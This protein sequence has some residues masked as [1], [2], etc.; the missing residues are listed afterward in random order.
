MKAVEVLIISEPNIKISQNKGLITDNRSDVAIQLLDK[1]IG[2]ES[3]EKGDGYVIIV[4]NRW[5]LYGCYVSPNIHISE[6]KKYIDSVMTNIRNSKKEAIFAGDLNAKSTAWG[7]PYTD[8]RGKYMEEWMDELNLVILNTGTTPTFERGNSRSFIDVTGTTTNIARKI[9]KWEVLTG[10]FLTFHNHIYFEMEQ[11][12]RQNYPQKSRVLFDVARFK[13]E[14]QETT[15]VNVPKNLHELCEILKDATRVSTLKVRGN[16]RTLPFWWNTEIEIQRKICM[17]LRRSI[18]RL[19]GKRG[20]TYV[21]EIINLQEQY[22]QARKD[23]KKFIAKSKRELWKELC[24]ELE[25]DIWG[26][27]YKVVMKN[28]GE[29]SLPFNLSEKRKEEIAEYLFPVKDDSWQKG[30]MTKQVTPFTLEEL[31]DATAKIKLG[32]APGPDQ[33]PPEA[34]KVAV[35]VIPDAILGIMNTLLRAQEF[36]DIWKIANVIFLWKGKPTELPSSFRTICMLSMLGKLFE[37][38]I[39]ERIE[40]EIE[41]NG[42]LSDRQYGFRKGRSTMQA[43]ERVT[44]VFKNSDK[45]WFVMV[46]VDVE[47]AFNCA[48]W[49][50]VIRELRSR[51][52]SSYLVNLVISY[53]EHRTIN[54]TKN[55][56]IEMTAGVP[57]GSVLGP[58]LWNIMY[59]RVLE[60]TLPDGATSVAYADDLVIMVEANT[61]I[62]VERTTNE[63]LYR[64]SSW[65]IRND[66]VLAPH[67]TEAIILKGGRSREQL[68]FHLRGTKIVP[69]QHLKYLGVYLN[70]KLSFAEH[71]KQVV[72]K[73]EVK[74]AQLTRILP[75]IGGPSSAKRAVMCG[76]IH[77]IVLY[78]AP[79]WH[80]VLSIKKYEIMMMGIQRRALLRIA[81]GYRTIS[82]SAVQVITGTPP[83]TLLAEERNRLYR[84]ENAHLKAV[85]EEERNI[86][87][88]KWQHEWEMNNETATWTRILIEDI[89][90]W[91][92]CKHRNLDYYLTQFLTGHGSFRQYLKR[93]NITENDDCLY[94]GDLDTAE[95]TI[96]ICDRWAEKRQELER[97]I[98]E[99]LDRNSIIKIMLKD[100]DSFNKVKH[101]I[102]DIVIKKKEEEKT[103][104]H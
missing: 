20:T 43:I 51:R 40:R 36:P 101:L 91:I 89:R 63:S 102:K 90:P 74:M 79:I 61:D 37:R 35:A 4:F 56:C 49:S 48:R 41:S 96:L 71:I 80:E 27:G 57:Q 66:L 55:K 54:V 53:F 59:D 92:N 52:V 45:K 62:E 64:I 21:D 31:I 50:L 5:Q 25:N 42:G 13:K 87:I 32:K 98:G 14:I 26:T 38:L 97:G 77:S 17:K 100:K 70:S 2:A 78:G 30:E 68:Y 33:I 69:V 65:M 18:T 34:V 82:T 28:I 86:T 103:M 10:E 58:L 88:D 60:V 46:A 29:T 12:K 39:K 11:R 75:N 67:K 84:R 7:S 47:N 72:K 16:K 93:M 83:I 15:S 19:N 73:A 6:F 24:N 94:C 99:R 81:M 23:L 95:H 85:R 44:E 9:K 104:E 1:D 8:E 76:V 3:I 22:R